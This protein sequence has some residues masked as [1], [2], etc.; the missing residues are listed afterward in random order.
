MQMSR[1]EMLK[2]MAAGVLLPELLAGTRNVWGQTTTGRRA[3]AL[4]IGMNGV[5]PTAYGGWPGTLNGCHADADAYDKIAR[6]R[7]FQTLKLRS[8]Q[9]KVGQVAGHILWAAKELQAGDIFFVAYSGHGGQVFDRNG[10]ESEDNR[11]ETWC[12]FDRQLIDDELALFW[13]YFQHDVR[14]LVASDSCHSGTVA[15]AREAARVAAIDADNQGSKL[16]THARSMWGNS[17]PSVLDRVKNQASLISGAKASA[18]QGVREAG[19]QRSNLA[20]FRE[21]P[22]AFIQPAYEARQAIYDQVGSQIRTGDKASQNTIKASGLLLAACKDDQLSME[23]GARGVF[24]SVFE[25]V[26]GGATSYAQL[27]Q[28]AKDKMPATQEPQLFPFGVLD[29]VFAREQKPLSV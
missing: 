15:R 23:M 18:L 22:E 12:L 6:D 10:D 21:L 11:D 29:Q 25:Q 28:L 17:A 1:R 24:S 14:I 26:V 3:L 4:T 19:A 5:D 8:S 27:I 16:A 20:L 7:G 2:A 13:R 9:A